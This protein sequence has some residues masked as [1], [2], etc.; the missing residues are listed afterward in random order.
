[1][2]IRR[3]AQHVYAAAHGVPVSEVSN[4]DAGLAEVTAL[5]EKAFTQ[6][7]GVDNARGRV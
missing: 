2:N 3:F 6:R 4:D 1:M 7:C 5:L